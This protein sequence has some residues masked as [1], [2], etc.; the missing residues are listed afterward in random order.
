VVL[1]GVTVNVARFAPV[2][3]TFDEQVAEDPANHWYV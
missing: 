2:T 1:V 3:A